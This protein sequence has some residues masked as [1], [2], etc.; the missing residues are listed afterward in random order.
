MATKNIGAPRARV[1]K[2]SFYNNLTER[3]TVTDRA[4]LYTRELSAKLTERLFYKLSSPR[5]PISGKNEGVHFSFIFTLA[6][7]VH[8]ALRRARFYC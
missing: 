3:Q 1:L 5:N 7:F 2:D 8:N 4:S 6:I